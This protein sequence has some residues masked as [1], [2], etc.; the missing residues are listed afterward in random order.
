MIKMSIFTIQSNWSNNQI[1]K[2]TNWPNQIW[3]NKDKNE[4]YFET[5]KKFTDHK[6]RM[7]GLLD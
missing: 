6:V 1:E 7:D 4:S 3:I 2:N 5:T